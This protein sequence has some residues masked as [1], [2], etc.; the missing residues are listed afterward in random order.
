ML[1]LPLVQ[2]AAGILLLT[3]LLGIGV[4]VVIA[5]VV[6]R[7]RARRKWVRWTGVVIQG[8]WVISQGVGLF[9]GP[10]VGGFVGLAL[11]AVAIVLLLMPAS[12]T[13]FDS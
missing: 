13:W 3:F 12:T 8:V 4:T 6:V 10:S 11:A 1:L 2:Q 5:V 9:S 7:M